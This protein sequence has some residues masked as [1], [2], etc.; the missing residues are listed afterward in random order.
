MKILTYLDKK[1]SVQT[2][3]DIT[4]AFTLINGEILRRRLMV[5]LEDK[6][7]FSP[8][9][10][11]KGEGFSKPFSGEIKTILQKSAI[12]TCDVTQ[13]DYRI[14]FSNL[15]KIDR[16]IRLTKRS[17]SNEV[18]VPPSATSSRQKCACGI[19]L[20]SPSFLKPYN[21]AG[22]SVTICLNDNEEGERG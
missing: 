20:V 11:V 6:A 1:L 18:S 5:P 19:M 17:N 7:L 9:D 22:H 13:V 16:P 12:I 10:Y 8:G 15:R 14:S 21:S 3:A 4:K 2:D